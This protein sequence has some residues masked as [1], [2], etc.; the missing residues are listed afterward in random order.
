MKLLLA[1]AS[2]V[3][4]LLLPALVL[5]ADETTARPRPDPARFAGE[6]AEFDNAEKA[7]PPARGGIVFT[8]SS[9]VR[10]W[11]VDEAFPGGSNANDL[12]AF[13]D[14]VVLRYRPKVLVVYTGSNDLHAKLTPAE[15]LA[16]YAKFLT[17]VHEKLPTARVVV[18]SVK[19]APSRASEMDAVRQLNAALESWTKDKPWIRWVE[20]SSYLLD[21]NGRPIESLYRADRLHLNDEGYAKW[22]AIIG[23]VVREEWAKAEKQP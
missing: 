7:N 19:F 22:N 13:A 11:K 9:S 23:P 8:G 21:S 5:R 20:A 4:L 1:P 17:M 10:L 15:A 12:V 14:R 3:A 18:S 6:I 2:L 16:D